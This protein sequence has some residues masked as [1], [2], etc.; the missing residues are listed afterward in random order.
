L[1]SQCTT[2]KA[3]G[4]RCKLAASRQY[5]LC[6]AH[7][8]ENAQQRRRTASR[9]GRGKPSREIRDLKKQ[10]EDLAA[11][12]LAGRVDRANAVV[13]NQILNTRARLIE[14]ERKVKE[15]EELEERLERLEQAQE[16]GGGQRW[17]A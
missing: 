17:G 16:E 15:T 6:W 8:P 10:L 12:V 2:I 1:A 9:G 3:N 5:G 14:L 11:D 13:V 4:E 7:S